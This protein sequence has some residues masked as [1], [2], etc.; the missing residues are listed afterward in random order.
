M[1]TLKMTFWDD[2]D[3]PIISKSVSG[4]WL[5][6]DAEEGLRAEDE[7]RAWDAGAEWSVATTAQGNLIVYIRH[8]NDGFRPS[9]DVH[10]DF[11]AMQN[12]SDENG[13]PRYPENVLAA[14]AAALGIP[15]ETELE[16]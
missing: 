15:F 16:L 12:A 14:T 5:V 10:E 7:T 6:G 13:E 11:D 9:M 3:R 8:C 4:R 1:K 2:Y